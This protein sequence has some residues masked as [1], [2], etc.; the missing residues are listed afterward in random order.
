MPVTI[1]EIDVVVAP[2]PAQQQ[3][4]AQAQPSGTPDIR[5]TLAL[6]QERCR[7]LKAE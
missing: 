6:L 1:G 4:T 3:P 5:K 7:R 2:S